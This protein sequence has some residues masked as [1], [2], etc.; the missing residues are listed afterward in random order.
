V[1]PNELSRLSGVSDTEGTIRVLKAIRGDL[2]ARVARIVAEYP[3]ET[4][5]LIYAL[6]QNMYELEQSRGFTNFTIRQL[7]QL[8]FVYLVVHGPLPIPN[9]DL[10]SESPLAQPPMREVVELVYFLQV[11]DGT[12]NLGG[13]GVPLSLSGGVVTEGE[14]DEE[15]AWVTEVN[16]NQQ[17]DPQ[18]NRE[19]LHAEGASPYIADIERYVYGYSVS[20]FVDAFS[21]IKRLAQVARVATDPS[22]EMITV[23]YDRAPPRLQALLELYSVTPDRLRH[24]SSPSFFFAGDKAQRGDAEIMETACEMDWLSYAPLLPAVY[25]DSKPRGA[26]V[27]S[28]FLLER[29]ATRANSAVAFRMHRAIETARARYPDLTPTVSRLVR[30]YHA[31]LE[32]KVASIF[33]EAGMHTLKNVT[34]HGKRA[35]PC[36]EIDVLAIGQP[37]A[38][39][40][41]LCVAE[42]KNTDVSFY[43][44][45]GAR[46]AAETIRRGSTQAARKSVWLQEHA[47]VLAELFPAFTQLTSLLVLPV[48]ITRHT[49]LPVEHGAVPVTSPYELGRIIAMLTGTPV[50]SWRADFRSA[51]KLTEI[52]RSAGPAP[53][54]NNNRPQNRIQPNSKPHIAASTCC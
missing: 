2:V 40:P 43:K 14:L 8:L 17:V 26:F 25:Y 5:A 24:H 45:T 21:D 23:D 38:G 42:V 15:S 31:E 52:R 9:S 20:D 19:Q 29:T 18:L 32:D 7:Q 35:L 39:P 13:Y 48:V 47:Q 30:D 6:V 44:D 27:V 3:R 28:G 16:L 50:A 33:S 37:V 36:G 11:L 54:L 1:A 41:L 53:S 49:A 22:G 4:C 51:A 12:I 46:H 10:L 34:H